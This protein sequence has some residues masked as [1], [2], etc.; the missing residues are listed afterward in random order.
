MNLSR[1]IFLLATSLL[2][3]LLL[4]TI[5]VASSSQTYFPLNHGDSKLYRFQVNGV[6]RS[7]TLTYTNAVGGNG[8]FVETD[9]ID[10]S[11][12]LYTN[13]AGALT[14]PGVILAGDYLWFANPLVVYNDETISNG[15][16]SSSSVS[17][18]YQG[19]HIFIT[20][21]TTINKVGTVQVPA[22]KFQDCRSVSFDMVV[23]IDGTSAPL[24]MHNVWTLA[25]R[26]G[27]IQVEVVDE[28]DH[29]LDTSELISGTVGGVDVRNLQWRPDLTPIY[30]ILLDD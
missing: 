14:M 27:K 4:A 11:Q 6:N 2:S 1:P 26:V 30:N 22:G 21:K 18:T 3:L 7:S 16:K 19:V 20:V 25:P 15:G 28:N 12:A 13:A 29:Y 23:Q 17:T 9:S 8:V 10:G 24:I 5:A